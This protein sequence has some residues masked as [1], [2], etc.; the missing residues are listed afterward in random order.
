MVQIN[1][2]KREVQC[3]VVYYGPA[4]SG[5]TAN[6][7]WIHE[8]S[9]DTVR[10]QLTTIATDTNRTLFFDFL[11]LDLG[12]VAGIRTKVHLYAIPYIAGQNALRMLVLEGADGIMF[13][14]DSA[15]HQ[16]SKNLEAHENL[17]ENL[18]NMDRDLADIPLVWQWNKSD[19]PDAMSAEELEEALNPEGHPAFS[20][21][22]EAGTGV[23]SALKAMTQAVLVD[24]A[25][26]MAGAPAAAPA[27]EAQPEEAPEEAAPAPAPQATPAA[28]P[29][30][31][32]PAPVPA[33][34]APPE[35]PLPLRPPEDDAVDER[36]ALPPLPEPEPEPEIDL[37][38]EGAPA[39]AAMAWEEPPAP[40]PLDAEPAPA[41]QDE[42]DVPVG[43][44]GRPLVEVTP[45]SDAPADAPAGAG[46]EPD[47]APPE[48]IREAAS[49]LAEEPAAEEPPAPAPE[50][51]P[52]PVVA[53]S[54]S[55]DEYA[56]GGGEPRTS[57]PLPAIPDFGFDEP[58]PTRSG[59]PFVPGAGGLPADDAG[60][61]PAP[62]GPRK[63]RVGPPRRPAAASWDDET[64][65]RTSRP[66]RTPR[67]AI[68]RRRVPRP[69]SAAEYEI[70]TTASLAAGATFTALGL[71]VVGYLVHAL[72]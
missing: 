32:A 30:E 61:A 12:H 57:A 37:E 45:G 54:G 7:R 47:F 10:G 62:A 18:G 44:D 53:T 67:P 5:K 71:A 3:K 36:P 20:A 2:A 8:R 58:S 19:L 60:A 27:P 43:I 68:D 9:P 70:P 38:P 46:E 17:R 51:E 69:P 39:T 64:P 55:W 49:G 33:A 72:L 11:P 29:E 40:P 31:E 59:E 25:K 23:F 41:P 35:R 26:M 15:V 66:R 65:A 4:R 1:F 56:P 13:V 22:A 21:A 14:A 52:E 24:V 63:V 42:S 34:P 6:L 16:L 48:F 50:P 28:T